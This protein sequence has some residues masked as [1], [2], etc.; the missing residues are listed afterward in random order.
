MKALIL[1]GGESSRLGRDKS[2]LTFYGRPPQREFLSDL[3][4]NYC[5]QVFLSCKN[6]ENI[7]ANLNPLKDRYD[8]KSPLNGIITALDLSP[9]DA[10][11]TVPVDMPNV[12]AHVIEFL[13]RQ[14]NE[15][16]IATCFYDSDLKFPEPLLAI[17]E[18]AALPLLKAF[19]KTGKKSPRA[20]LIENNIKIVTSPFQNLHLNINTNED[21]KRYED[22]QSAI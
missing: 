13:I 20:F 22:N 7:P 21:M 18:P 12:T 19:E 11:L 6:C 2:L 8:Y 17:W 15:T 4:S 10:W 3:L 16:S 1:A 9:E 5:E 14:R